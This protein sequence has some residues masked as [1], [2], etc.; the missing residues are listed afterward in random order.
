MLSS[1]VTTKSYKTLTVTVVVDLISDQLYL[2]Y[3]LLLFVV[4]TVRNEALN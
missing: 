3:L 1:K 2:E 4:L